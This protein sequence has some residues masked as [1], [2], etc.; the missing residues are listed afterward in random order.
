MSV[1]AATPSATVQSA[2]GDVDY[3]VPEKY[4]VLPSGY[5]LIASVAQAEA[6]YVMAWGNDR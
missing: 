5:Q 2:E 1:A 6:I 3:S 4:T